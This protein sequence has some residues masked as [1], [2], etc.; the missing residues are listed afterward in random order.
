MKHLLFLGFFLLTSIPQA[1]ATLYIVIKDPGSSKTAI[2]GISSGPIGDT[3]YPTGDYKPAMQGKL[4]VGLVGWSGSYTSTWD[5]DNKQVL[6]MIEAG[7][8]VQQIQD[9]V[10][11]LIGNGYR[12]FV[13]IKANGEIGYVFPPSGCYYPICGVRSSER[14]DFLAIGGGLQPNVIEETIK[15]FQPILYN[16][17]IP[18]ECRV[19]HS[20]RIFIS[21]GG[22]VKPF[23]T[24]KLGI[25]DPI[26]KKQLWLNA[27]KASSDEYDLITE[28][29]QQLSSEGILCYNL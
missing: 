9:F 26:N 29:R 13:F 27:M 6:S 1:S 11:K 20:L 4:N 5:A 7:Y 19:L 8:S 10:T 14:A 25:N 28:F 18:F 15:L 17:T 22:E 23:N 3:S 2:A 12:R 16:T 24:A 21:T